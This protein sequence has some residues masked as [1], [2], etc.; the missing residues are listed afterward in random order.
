MTDTT[1]TY[2]VFGAY[3]GVGSAL[4]RKL[5]SRGARLAVSGRDPDRLEALSSEIGGFPVIADTTDFDAVDAAVARTVDHFGAIDGVALCVGSLML[6]P[7]HMTKPEE[8][9]ETLHTNLTSAFAVLRAVARPMMKEKRGSIVFVSTAAA[10]IGLPNHEAIAAAKG[11]IDAL[12]R[13]AAATYGKAGIRV[14]AVAPGLVDTPLTSRITGSDAARA[15]SEA[16]HA[17]GRLGTAEEVAE[18]IRWLLSGDASWVTGQTLGV[19][20]GLGA[21]RSA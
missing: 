9:L 14:N 21:V 1:P 17:L 3:G 20:G 13:S 10:S 6:K 5:H 8:W 16:M 7:A 2:L 19:D 15:S 12:V 11:G 18:S 4:A